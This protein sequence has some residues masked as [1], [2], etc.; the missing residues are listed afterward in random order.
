MSMDAQGWLDS[1]EL[2]AQRQAAWA[3]YFAAH[4]DVLASWAHQNGYWPEGH[5]Y[6][7]SRDVDA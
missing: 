2:E 4:P 7:E 1:D 6:V 3:E 5:V